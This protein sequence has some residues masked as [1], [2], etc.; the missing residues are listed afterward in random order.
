MAP[1]P[2]PPAAPTAGTA[3]TVTPPAPGKTTTR[4]LSKTVLYNGKFY[5]PGE[6]V[7][8]P[9]DFRSQSE[10]DAHI[11]TAGVHQVIDNKINPPDDDATTD[12]GEGDE[13]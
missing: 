1:N 2:T 13:E 11:R 8:V 7:E 5:G 9:A 3:R 4:N 10:I 6:K 12:N